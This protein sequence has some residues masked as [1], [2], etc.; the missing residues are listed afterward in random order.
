MEDIPVLVG[1]A[2]HI[3]SL[4]LV[5]MKMESLKANNGTGTISSPSADAVTTKL[6]VHV[7][8]MQEEAASVAVKL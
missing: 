3:I 8:A 1:L 6:K 4:I 2:V 7:K 5:Q